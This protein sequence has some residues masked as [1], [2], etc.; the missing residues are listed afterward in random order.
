[1][2]FGGTVQFSD[3]I[4]GA[5]HWTKISGNSGTESNGTEI[6][7][8]FVS[9]IL[10]NLWSFCFIWHS[11]SNFVQTLGPIPS[12]DCRVKMAESS[13]YRY[14]CSICF[15][16]RMICRSFDGIWEYWTARSPIGKSKTIRND[17]NSKLKCTLL[18]T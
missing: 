11:I 6:F 18:C 1:M 15:F 4:L 3:E 9:K 7:E 2:A 8:K 17:F 5:I 14:Q 12:R 16:L 13:L 10:V